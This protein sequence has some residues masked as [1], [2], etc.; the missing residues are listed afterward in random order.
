MST[1][2]PHIT[3]AR[4]IERKCIA[5]WW[6]KEQVWQH[7]LHHP[8][9]FAPS[10]E[11]RKIHNVYLDDPVASLK[12][13]H[14]AGI[15]SRFKLRIRWYG[16][17]REVFMHP[18]L[19]V[20]HKEHYWGWKE[21]YPLPNLHGMAVQAWLKKPSLPEAALASPSLRQFSWR[22]VLLNAYRRHYLESAQRQYRVTLD[23]GLCFFPS[24]FHQRIGPGRF[25]SDQLIIELKYGVALEST[26]LPVVPLLPFRATAYSKY[27]TGWQL[28]YGN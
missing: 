10:F 15:S 7:F 20:K 28:L 17:T 25:A 4:R 27:L 18:Q 12:T 16:E 1:A 21:V 26:A 5:P 11:A 24:L 3:T 22:P 2:S 9:R 13:A 14:E 23:E 19:E 8:L 6:Q